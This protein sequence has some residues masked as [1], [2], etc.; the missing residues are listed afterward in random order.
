MELG[1]SEDRLVPYGRD[2]AKIL[3]GEGVPQGKLILVSAITPTKAGEGKTTTSVSLAQGL[4]HIGEKA[5]VVLREPSLGPCMGVK[6]GAAGGGHAQVIPM[7]DINLHFTG[8]FHAVAAAHNLLA[9]ALDNHLHQGNALKIEP[10]TVFW[11]RVMD[12]NDRSLRQIMVGMGGRTMGVPRQT[13]F[14]ITAASEIMAILCMSRDL[15]DLQARM[16]NI[17]IGVEQ[18]TGA[19]IHARQLGITGAMATLLKDAIH[20]NLVQTLEGGPAIIHGGPFANIA[21]GTNTIIATRTAMELA[22]YVVTEAGFGFDLGGEKFLDIKCPA[23]GFTP[24]AI[25]LVATVRALKAHGGVAVKD[26][27]GTN[28]GAVVRGLANLAH[29]LEAAQ[30]YGVPVVISLNHFSADHP[31]EVAAVANFCKERGVPYAENRG[32]SE[33]GA[34][35]TDMAR[36]VLAAL[37]QPCEFTPLYDWAAPVTEKI[38]RICT[39]IYGADG[40]SFEPRARAALRRIERFGLSGLPICMAKTP[41]SLSDDPAKV[42]RP[43]GFTITVREIEIAAGAGFII[44]I[45]GEI[46][47]MPGL[48]KRPSAENMGI[49]EDGLIFGLS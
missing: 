21:Q 5:C 11:K 26:Q 36:A 48:P 44:P 32:W 34:G 10:R 20:P 39:E 45:T 13:G 29:H 49:D 9:A 35:A 24:G 12:M 16:G 47:R 4:C 41:A 33:G 8:D 17:L 27:D 46:M 7:E 2:K 1:L 18:G 31:S 3:P 19:A 43:T 40:V 30:R 15:G 23:A 22:D 38:S 28:A 14:D 42:G 37:K 6:G 25:V